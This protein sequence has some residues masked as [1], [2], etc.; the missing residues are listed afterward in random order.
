VTDVDPSSQ[1]PP[2][3]GSGP[4]LSADDL[5]RLTGGRLLAR[6]DRPIRGGAVDSRAVRPGELFVGGRC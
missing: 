4:S 3:V 1:V 2:D 6:S 5:A